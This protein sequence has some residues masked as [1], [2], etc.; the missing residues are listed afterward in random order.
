MECPHGQAVMGVNISREDVEAL[1]YRDPQIAPHIHS[2][3]LS[4]VTDVTGTS[5]LGIFV[6]LQAGATIDSD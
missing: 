5:R 4:I 2:F 6:E 3:Y 1:I